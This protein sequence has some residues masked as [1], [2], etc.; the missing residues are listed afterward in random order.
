M[1]RRQSKTLMAL[2][3]KQLKKKNT[4]CAA[5]KESSYTLSAGSYPHSICEEVG[6][7]MT[8]HFTEDRTERHITPW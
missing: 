8:L 7:H 1:G 2:V 5:Y 3:I 4:I 6:E